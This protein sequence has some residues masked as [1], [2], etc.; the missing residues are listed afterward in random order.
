MKTF[1]LLPR[2]KLCILFLVASQLGTSACARHERRRISPVENG[3]YIGLQ[4]QM[5]AGTASPASIISASQEMRVAVSTQMKTA[6][7]NHYSLIDLKNK[8]I[9]FPDGRAFDSLKHL[10]ACIAL[11]SAT[12]DTSD[13]RF[14]DRMRECIAGFQDTHLSAKPRVPLLTVSTG[15]LVQ[16]IGGHYF[17]SARQTEILKYVKKINGL[18]NLDEVTAIGNELLEIDGEK[19]ADLS[20]RLESFVNASSPGYRKGTA[21]F[22]L[23]NRSFNYPVKKSVHLVIRAKT[24]V[25]FHYELPWWASPETR[26]RLDVSEYFSA[27]G[28][29]T[30]DRVKMIYDSEGKI[31]WKTVALTYHGYLNSNPL[32]SGD[33]FHPLV[34]FS[35]AGGLP[36][37]R[38]GTITTPTQNFCYAQFLT[39]S[40]ATLTGPDGI[41]VD[42]IEVAR[43]FVKSCKANNLNLVIDLRSNGGGDGSYPA[44]IL[45]LLTPDR[46]TLGNKVMAFRINQISARLVSSMNEHPELAAGDLSIIGNRLFDELSNA[47]RAGLKMTG[48]IPETA[49]TVAD[50]EVGGYAGKVLVLITPSCFSACDGTAAI[51]SRTGRATVIGTHTNGTGA[52]YQGSANVDSSFQDSFDE[53]KF[54]IPNYQFGYS[55]KPF[56]ELKS[57]PFETVVD[58]FFTENIPTVANI[59][60]EPTL[61]DI[62]GKKNSWLDAVNTELSKP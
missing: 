31:D 47:A 52:G 18:A 1:D 25:I 54:S 5:D 30:S 3:V 14:V 51:L 44:K 38:F 41:A 21:D 27:L 26:N 8:R 33:T 39:F 49:G 16:N 32:V 9:H 55:G 37:A 43:R 59:K 57:V 48:A 34:T 7:M 15:I 60:V 61:D 10:D 13:F 12:T 45:A 20:L 6:L 58:N 46:A 19:P 56:A 36:G 11:E 2:D 29:P 53:L 28:I 17:I 40:S 50:K 22:S 35:A 23:F 42:F 4:A 62:L 24:G